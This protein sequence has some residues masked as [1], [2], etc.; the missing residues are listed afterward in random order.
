MIQLGELA[1]QARKVHGPRTQVRKVD[2]SSL[3]GDLP[4][5]P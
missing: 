2:L 4:D 1:L 3:L 5:L